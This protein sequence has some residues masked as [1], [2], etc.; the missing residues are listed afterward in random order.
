MKIQ[1]VFKAGNSVVVA[2]PVEYQKALGL[3]IGSQVIISLGEGDVIRIE[4][5]NKITDLKNRMRRL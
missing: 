5:I 3:E 1:K 4:D 2:I